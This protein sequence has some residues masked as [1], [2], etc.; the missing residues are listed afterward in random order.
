MLDMADMETGLW[1]EESRMDTR[2][3]L[4]TNEVMMTKRG[5]ENDTFERGSE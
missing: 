5:D 3:L 4:R 1:S 2:C